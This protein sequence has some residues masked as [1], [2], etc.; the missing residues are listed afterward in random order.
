LPEPPHWKHVFLPLLQN[1]HFF[2]PCLLDMIDL[3]N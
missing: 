2:Q 3:A 1:V